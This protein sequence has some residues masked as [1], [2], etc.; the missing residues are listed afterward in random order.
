MAS[1]KDRRS[2]TGS[3]TLDS[4]GMCT[5]LETATRIVTCL[6]DTFHVPSPVFKANA[7]LDGC[8]AV[9]NVRGWSNFQCTKGIL[10]AVGPD[11]SPTFGSFI[12]ISFPNPELRIR[13]NRR[14]PVIPARLITEI[15]F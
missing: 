15:Q 6:S 14:K 10:F 5:S 3:R 4:G 12:P 13:D 7:Y 1:P 2:I 8:C 9:V 11:R